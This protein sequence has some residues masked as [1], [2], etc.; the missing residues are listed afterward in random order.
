MGV[1]CRTYTT[2]GIAAER[3]QGRAKLDVNTLG[4]VLLAHLVSAAVELTAIP[5]GG[6]SATG[7]ESG[8]VVGESH[9][10][11]A[12]LHTESR[13]AQAWDLADVADTVVALPSGSCGQVDLLEQ[14][15]LA[16]EC[17]CLFVGISPVAGAL[18]PTAESACGWF[19]LGRFCWTYGDG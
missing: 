5:R 10:K 14:G 16:N 19:R 9:T 12:V 13:E 8:D 3:A 18:D 1:H 7:R 4:A 17:L 11:R 6:D 2:L 15:K